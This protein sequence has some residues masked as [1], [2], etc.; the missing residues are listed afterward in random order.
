MTRAEFVEMVSRLV[1]YTDRDSQFTD[2]GADDPYY[3]AIVTAAAQGWIGR[4]WRR[5]IPA[6]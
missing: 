6:E 2:V 5:N 3:H 4:I 1:A